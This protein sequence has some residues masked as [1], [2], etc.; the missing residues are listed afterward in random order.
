MEAQRNVP[1]IQGFASTSCRWLSHLELKHKSGS[2]HSPLG[3]M[4]GVTPSILPPRPQHMADGKGTE[5]TRRLSWCLACDLSIDARLY[6][7]DAQILPRVL[8]E[9]FFAKELG[10]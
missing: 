10:H 2:H 5:L 8:S 1:G 3:S 4:V 6:L 7:T 9:G